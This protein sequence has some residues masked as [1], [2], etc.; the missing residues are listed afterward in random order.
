MQFRRWLTRSRPTFSNLSELVVCKEGTGA[1]P[2]IE[3]PEFKILEDAVVLK[4]PAASV[5]YGRL[6]QLGMFNVPSG[7]SRPFIKL[8]HMRNGFTKFCTGVEPVNLVCS[9]PAPTNNLKVLE[10]NYEDEAWVIKDAGSRILSYSG[11]I[12]VEEDKLTGRGVVVLNGQGPI[13]ELDL[14]K[15]D[16]VLLAPESVCAYTADTSLQLVKLDALLT[17]SKAVKKYGQLLFGKHYEGILTVLTRMANKDKIYYRAKGP[18]RLLLQTH[19][20]PGSQ[21]YSTAELLQSMK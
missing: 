12:S 13:Y 14:G 8:E 9:S 16:E 10:V 19:Y 2:F 11:N 21:E 7:A 15:C 4:I 1:G 3:L 17:I 20:L 18:G 6:E 5:V